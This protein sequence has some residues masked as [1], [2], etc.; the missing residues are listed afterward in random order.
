M[1]FDYLPSALMI[2]TPA[3][4]AAYIAV[5]NIKDQTAASRPP[6]FKDP[7]LENASN[8]LHSGAT[9]ET[10]ETAIGSMS[11]TS[12]DLD[13]MSE[14][15]FIEAPP[16][17]ALELIQKGFQDPSGVTPGLITVFILTLGE[18]NERNITFETNARNARSRNLFFFYD[19]LVP[20][21]QETSDDAHLFGSFLAGHV[22][23]SDLVPGGDL[24]RMRTALIT[25]EEGTENP[26]R[27]AGEVTAFLLRIDGEKL[28]ADVNGDGIADNVVQS[29][30]L[31]LMISGLKRFNTKDDPATRKITDFILGENLGTNLQKVF[32]AKRTGEPGEISGRST[33][34]EY[35]LDPSTLSLKPGTPVVS[36]TGEV[37]TLGALFVLFEEFCAFWTK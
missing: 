23:G 27:L 14:I 28:N 9:M 25:P 17:S 33:F 5:P 10:V 16:G 4:F 15:P 37:S 21:L 8:L 36:Q 2:D 34:V 7:V 13:P 12:I 18:D 29:R 24:D 6:A 11:R 31:D 20:F 3:D 19:T 26:F 22:E 30:K 32:D 1:L 35:N